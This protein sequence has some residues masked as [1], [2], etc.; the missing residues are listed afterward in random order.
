M[1]DPD[2]V[3]EQAVPIDG[4]VPQP[5]LFGGAGGAPVLWTGST[6]GRDVPGR[7]L[8]WQPW[9]GAFTALEVLDDTPA[10]VMA[11]RC[12]S[13]PGAALWLD[14]TMPA[15]PRLAA[16]RF[17]CPRRRTRLCRGRSWSPTRWTPCPTGW[18]TTACCR[19]MRIRRRGS[20][21]ARSGREP[22]GPERLRERPDLRRRQDPGRRARRASP[23][24]WS[25]A[26]R[27]GDEM[28]VGGAACAGAVVTGVACHADGR[29]RGAR[30]SRGR[31]R[32]ARPAS[33]PSGST[34][35]R[36][37]R[38]ECAPCPTSSKACVSN[39][40]VTAPRNAVDRHARMGRGSGRMA[41]SHNAP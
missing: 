26:T 31:S 7:W 23:R 27:S 28:E 2:G 13:G 5:V 15:A 10:S 35:P 16:L 11:S 3:T 6:S 39:L 29:P 24:W 40:R 36:G 37:S 4:P 20:A 14:T 30:T 33:A 17:D 1:I 25:C 21:D 38:W 18:R 32:A 12:V 34:R 8:R 19:S 22:A 41:S 9:A